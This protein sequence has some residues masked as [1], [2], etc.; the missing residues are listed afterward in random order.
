MFRTIQVPDNQHFSCR[1]FVDPD[2]RGMALMGHMVHHYSGSVHPDDLVW[3][4]IF[5]WNVA[6]VRTFERIG[7]RH[8][9]D[10]WTIFLFGLRIHRERHFPPGAPTTLS[11]PGRR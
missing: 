10:Y 4:L 9:G 5:H 7:W 3:G 6:S 8:L 2:Y 11:S 1:S